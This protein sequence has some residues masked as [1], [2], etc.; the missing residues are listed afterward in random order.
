MRQSFTHN[1]HSIWVWSL[2]RPSEVRCLEWR[3]VEIDFDAAKN[4]KRAV[5][6]IDRSKASI[7]KLTSESVTLDDPFTVVLLNFG[8]ETYCDSAFV[9]P[10]TSYP[11]AKS[12]K[13]LQV[14]TKTH[15]LSAYTLKRG[16]ASAH[17]LQFRSFERLFV[18]RRWSSVGAAR[19]YI[20]SAVA[21]LV[22]QRVPDDIVRTDPQGARYLR[23]LQR[24]L[25][26]GGYSYTLEG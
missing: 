23:R 1:F 3:D 9:C 7:R 10:Y 13:E 16:G 11:F 12:L 24:K 5:A 4:R 19:I 17:Y 25:G 8:K 20:D 15:G 6:C 2:F 21:S 14:R 22:R 18:D 26:V